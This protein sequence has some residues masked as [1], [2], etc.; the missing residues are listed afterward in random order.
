MSDVGLREPP[1]LRVSLFAV[2]RDALGI[3]LVGL[4]LDTQGEGEVLDTPR[5]FDSDEFAFFHQ[6]ESQNPV[7]QT[8]S[9][10]AEVQRKTTGRIS[11]LG[12]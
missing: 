4:L 2:E 5:D 7:V 12:Q 3:V 1:W 9:L 6:F 10:H 8:G 11:G